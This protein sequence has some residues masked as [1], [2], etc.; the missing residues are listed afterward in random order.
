[1]IQPGV[2]NKMKLTSSTF[3]VGTYVKVGRDV[4]L[5][6]PAFVFSKLLPGTIGKIT[7]DS[8]RWILFRSRNLSS[9]HH[10]DMNVQIADGDNLDHFEIVD[11]N[12]LI[13]IEEIIDD[14]FNNTEGLQS[15]IP[16]V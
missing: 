9:S 3:K 13:L 8:P 4:L 10:L 5:T 7:N 16:E 12:T 11:L 15:Q 2:N 1:M 14:I 6:H